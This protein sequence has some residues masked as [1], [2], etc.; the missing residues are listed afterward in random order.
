MSRTAYTLLITSLLVAGCARAPDGKGARDGRSA[1]KDH[2]DVGDLAPIAPSDRD[3]GG[4]VVD[5]G[6][7]RARFPPGYPKPKRTIRKLREGRA[8]AFVSGTADGVCLVL[9]AEE[10]GDP[11]E[12]SLP[13]FEQGLIGEGGHLEAAKS[14]TYAGKPARTGLFTSRDDDGA[15][16]YWRYLAVT[17]GQRLFA[18]IFMSKREPARRTPEVDAFLSS[19]RVGTGPVP[20]PDDQGEEPSSDGDGGGLSI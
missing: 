15:T 11:I 1:Q 18:A 9:G 12:R 8:V 7:F 5:V 3:G 2:D 4:A 14:F 16:T 20:R 6:A 17:D 19:L 10:R 13:S